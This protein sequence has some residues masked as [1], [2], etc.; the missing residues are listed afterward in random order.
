MFY[1]IFTLSSPN[2][3]YARF[4]SPKII[5]T[6]FKKWKKYFFLKFFQLFERWF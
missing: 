3:R 4:F 2:W 6:F 1:R 5:K